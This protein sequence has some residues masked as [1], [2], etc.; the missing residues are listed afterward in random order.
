MVWCITHAHAILLLASSTALAFNSISAIATLV[1]FTGFAIVVVL[2]ALAESLELS[3]LLTGQALSTAMA[4]RCRPASK[5]GF[6]STTSLGGSTRALLPATVFTP[7]VSIACT[8]AA[9]LVTLAMSA[10]LLCKV[11]FIGRENVSL[12]SRCITTLLA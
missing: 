8:L 3:I 2:V 6:N 1:P 4:C 9:A 7:E 11:F 5:L 10:A 12:S